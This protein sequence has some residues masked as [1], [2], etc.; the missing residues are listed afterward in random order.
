MGNLSDHPEII[1][2]QRTGYPTWNQPEGE[3]CCECGKRILEDEDTYE[4]RTHKI[5]C[6]DC[7]KMLHR[8]YL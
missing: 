7:L 5:L 8:R 4:C 1:S 2:I 3:Y 6:E